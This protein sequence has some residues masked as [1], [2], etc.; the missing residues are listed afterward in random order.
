MESSQIPMTPSVGNH[1]DKYSSG[2][3]VVQR[4]MRGFMENLLELAAQGPHETIL[5]AGCGEGH[6]ARIVLGELGPRRYDACDLAPRH[7]LMLP[8]F[9]D[10]QQASIYALP[11]PDRHFDLVLACEVLEHLEDP[12]LAMVELSRVAKHAII[13]ST[14]REPLWRCLNVLRGSY[15]KA[16]GNTPGHIQHFSRRGLWH[17]CSPY[18]VDMQ[19]RQPIPWT[20]LKGRPRR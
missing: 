6:L 10:Y 13:V 17:L 4:L 18:L 12:R 8:R 19:D 11:Y 5:E 15:L 16:A 7:E 2:N 3:P 9:V 1:Y 20:I 14:P